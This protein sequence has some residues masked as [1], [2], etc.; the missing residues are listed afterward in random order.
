MTNRADKKVFA[1]WTPPAKKLLETAF[2]RF[3]LSARGLTRIIR[4]GKDDSRLTGRDR[5]TG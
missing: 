3:K 5:H 4:D 2:T 1:P